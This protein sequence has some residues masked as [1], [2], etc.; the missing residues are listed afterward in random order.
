M[1][2]SQGIASGRSLSIA[3]GVEETSPRDHHHAP[4]PAAHKPE[5]LTSRPF[6]NRATGALA[7][8]EGLIPLGSVTKTFTAA[9]VMQLLDAG[10][11]SLD[12]PAHKHVDPV[13]KRLNGTTLLQ[14]WSGDARIQRVTVGQLLSMRSGINDYDDRAYEAFTLSNPNATVSPFDLLRTVNKTWMFPPGEGG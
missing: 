4:D 1:G 8:P 11:L 7:K 2:V 14:V 10:L 3:S 13:L 12:D 5:R 6:Q 9:A